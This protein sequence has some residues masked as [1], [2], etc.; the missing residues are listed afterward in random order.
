MA[1][2]ALVCLAVL[3]V[4]PAK[5]APRPAIAMHGEP[6]LDPNSASAFPY[7]NPAARQGGSFTQAVVG[8]F[9]SLNPFIIKGVPADGLR[10]LVFE[11]LM[12]RSLDEP[13]TLYGLIAE[14]IDTPDDRSRVT[15]RLRPEARFSNGLHITS[16]DV[17][18]S[19][20]TLRDKGLPNYRLYF[21]A[22]T[23]VE[24]PDA[25]T[26]TFIFDPPANDRELPLMLGLL[27][28]LSKGDLAKRAF[29][30]TTLEPLLGSGP[31]VV[32][33]VEPGRSIVYRRNPSYWGGGLWLNQGLYNFER[34]RFDYFRDAEAVF[35]ALR[36]GLADLR[37]EDDAARWQSRY[38]F[39]AARQ[40]RVKREAFAHGRPS[41]MYGYVFNTRRPKL[42]D[43]RVRRALIL[44]F[45]FD[46]ANKSLLYGAFT[47][48]TSF[49]DNSELAAKGP[50]TADERALLAQFPG[51]VTDEIMANGFSPPSG[52]D[53]A[54]A[55]A[56]R[57][58]AL[59]LLAEAGYRINSGK[60]TEEKSRTPLS[61]EILLGSPTEEHVALTY[62]RA[63]TAAGIDTAVRAVDAAQY[64]RR[65]RSFDYDIVSFT[66]AGTLSPGKEQAFRWG[67]EAADAP[68][69]YNFAGVRSKAVDGLVRALV[70]AHTRA[71]LVAAARALDR[72]L[73]SGAYVMPLYF[74]PRDRLAYSARIAPPPKR[75][76]WGYSASPGGASPDAAALF[77]QVSK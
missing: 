65:L 50:A 7:A 75:P 46:W 38:D 11:R 30:K 39:P 56:N 72:V 42:A 13:F 1:V 64:E 61:L 14:T 52:G 77:Y 35:G 29:D 4:A 32:E 37:L 12:K 44:L 76:L 16:D 34:I 51:A 15:F 33:K 53:A 43:P 54:H 24:R 60:L 9:D 26:V 28:I 17:L 8:T 62:A 40:G 3:S 2:E 55:R 67:T 31:Y 22:V 10:E 48:I 47:R 71:E 18:F 45:D 58:A 70:S 66:W 36:A 5:A 69:S 49:F 21:Q 63:L 20:Q 6:V 25:R 23:K 41:G 57:R 74:A 73:L 19:F 27:P 59:R 68:G